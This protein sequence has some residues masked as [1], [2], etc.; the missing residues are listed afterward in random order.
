MKCAYSVIEVIKVTNCFNNAVCI[1]L[2]I[3]NQDNK[4]SCYWCKLKFKE[5]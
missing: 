2:N 5:S 1:S 4:V 3:S